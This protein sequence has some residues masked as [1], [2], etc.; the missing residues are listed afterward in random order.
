MSEGFTNKEMLVRIMSQQDQ[1]KTTFEGKLN[2]VIK[3]QAVT[4]GKVKF[5]AKVLW[6][7]AG[8]TLTA[9]L[10]LIGWMLRIAI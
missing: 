8:G 2:E 4:N 6:S 5:L 9:F 7:L 3:G 10:A 1:M